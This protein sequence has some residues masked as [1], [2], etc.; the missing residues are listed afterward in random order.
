[1]ARDP[2]RNAY[3]TVGLPKDSVAYQRLLQDAAES[4]IS[5]PSLIALRVADWY[6]LT[7]SGTL[8]LA[9]Q[10]PVTSVPGA[11]RERDEQATQQT[12]AQANAEAAAAAWLDD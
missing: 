2:D 1:M 11:E 7:A 9:S 3:H 10:G 5:I 6:R 12:Q 8:T 4:N